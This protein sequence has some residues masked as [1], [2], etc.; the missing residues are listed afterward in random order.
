MKWEGSGKDG[1]FLFFKSRLEREQTVKLEAKSVLRK[2][3]ISDAVQRYC[4]LNGI[5]FKHALIWH[6]SGI[7]NWGNWSCMKNQ[8]LANARGGSAEGLRSG[9]Q[10]TEF[11]CFYQCPAGLLERV[12]LGARSH[13]FIS[14]TL[15][16]RWE[17]VSAIPSLCER[18][19]FGI[20]CG[21]AHRSIHWLC[22]VRLPNLGTL[23]L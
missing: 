18:R 11:C 5:E 16:W 4:N 20:A 1:C 14:G 23:C 7:W 10:Q 8:P 19:E 12:I 3:V 13:H 15:S 22:C 9:T 2:K 6:T 21:V 17:A